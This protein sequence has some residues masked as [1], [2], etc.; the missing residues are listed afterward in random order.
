MLEKS[1]RAVIERLPDSKDE[2]QDQ[3]DLAFCQ[4]IAQGNSLPTPL[5]VHRHPCNSRYRPLKLQ[6]NN[7]GERDTFIAGFN[8]IRRSDTSITAIETS[9]RIR[10]D[11]TI[12]ELKTLRTSRKFVYD[13]NKKAGKT[14]FIMSD[15]FYKTNPNPRPFV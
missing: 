1:S 10:R 4:S 13:E 2:H 3:K 12:D 8:K 9:P 5:K 7:K 6:F 15:I 14:I 11:L